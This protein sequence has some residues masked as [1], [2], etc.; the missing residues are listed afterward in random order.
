MVPIM[1]VEPRS[2][3]PVDLEPLS[4][5]NRPT[6]ELEAVAP[7]TIRIAPS[8]HS[9]TEFPRLAGYVITSELARGGMGRVLAGLEEKLDRE[10]AIKVLLPGAH[11]SRFITESRITAKLPHPSIPP[12]YALGSLDDGSPFLAMKLVRGKTLAE[13]LKSRPQVLHD[14]PRLSRSVRPSA[15]LIHKASSIVISSLLTSWSVPLAKFR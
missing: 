12:V 1:P 5:G 2:A 9:G 15:L 8:P 11:T 13:E 14:L 10:V 3:H 6:A 4:I 7:S